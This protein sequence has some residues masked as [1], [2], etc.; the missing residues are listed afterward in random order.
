M[1]KTDKDDLIAD[2]LYPYSIITQADTIKCIMSLHLLQV[3]YITYR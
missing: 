1:Q 3:Y 2:Y